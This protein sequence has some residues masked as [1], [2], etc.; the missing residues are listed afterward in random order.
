MYLSCIVWMNSFQ[1]PLYVF[2]VSVF[3]RFVMIFFFP[4]FLPI[5]PSCFFLSFLISFFLLSFFLSS[6]PLF[7]SVFFLSF[8]FFLSFVLPSSLM[9]LLSFVLSFVLSVVRSFFHS[10]FLPFLLIF[11]I[12]SPCFA[13]IFFDV[14]GGGVPASVWSVL[15]VYFLLLIVMRIAKTNSLAICCH[16]CII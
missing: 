16:T 10:F 2:L 14:L 15:N 3:F 11:N 12:C 8:D 13:S 4:S 6:F 9:S 5:F 7:R 1:L